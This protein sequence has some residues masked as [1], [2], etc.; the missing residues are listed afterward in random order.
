MGIAIGEDKQAEERKDYEEFDHGGMSFIPTCEIPPPNGS[1]GLRNP[2]EGPALEADANHERRVR[3][4]ARH[5]T[6][7]QAEQG[8]RATGPLQSSKRI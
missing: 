6:D 2:L 8:V 7:S 5:L 4:R 3:R 1:R